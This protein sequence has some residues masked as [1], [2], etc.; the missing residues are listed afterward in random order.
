MK[1]RK[2]VKNASD[3]RLWGLH[4][5]AILCCKANVEID[6]V[7]VDLDAGRRRKTTATT[8][9]TGVQQSCVATIGS[10]SMYQSYR[11]ARRAS[12]QQQLSS[13]TQDTKCTCS[14]PEKDD[15]ANVTFM[16]KGR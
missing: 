8:T 7:E 10:R 5:L 9:P 1:R 14:K 16:V 13:K 6:D 2:K 11:V 4:T 15:E 12:E 3:N